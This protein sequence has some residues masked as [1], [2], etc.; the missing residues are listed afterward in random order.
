MSSLYL[1]TTQTISIMPN[2]A[3]SLRDPFRAASELL[4]SPLTKRPHQI[5]DF[6]FWSFPPFLPCLQCR[7]EEGR[8]VVRKLIFRINTNQLLSHEACALLR[9]T[10]PESC[11]R[12]TQG[13]SLKWLLALPVQS[14]QAWGVLP[15]QWEC[16]RL[17]DR[18]RGSHWDEFPQEPVQPRKHNS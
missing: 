11:K 9:S 4:L 16:W 10:F 18:D 15:Y 8:A 12:L 7:K 5:K 14:Q 13:R 1:Q 17:W 3:L 2:F 6:I